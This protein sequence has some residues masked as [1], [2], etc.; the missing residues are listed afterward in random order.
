MFSFF[1]FLSIVLLI[2]RPTARHVRIF[3]I[4]IRTRRVV[5]VISRRTNASTMVIF[6]GRSR[7]ELVFHLRVVTSIASSFLRSILRQ[8]GTTYTTMLISR[9]NSLIIFL[10]RLSRGFLSQGHLSCHSSQAGRINSNR[11]TFI[12][13]LSNF[14]GNNGSFFHISSTCS[15]VL[16]VTRSQVT[17]VFFLLSRVYSVTG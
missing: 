16:I 15:Q 1:T 9:G 11:F 10:L 12:F 17:N 3:I 14:S 2:R 13:V 6:T 7:F 4:S 5:S 8:G